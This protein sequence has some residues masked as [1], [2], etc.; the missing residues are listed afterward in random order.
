MSQNGQRHFENLAAFAQCEQLFYRKP[1]IAASVM[2]NR[3]K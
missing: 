3:G 1:Q 2:L